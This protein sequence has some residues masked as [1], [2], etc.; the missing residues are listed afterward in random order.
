MGTIGFW[1]VLIA[2][3]L[4]AVGLDLWLNRNKTETP[5]LKQALI[6]TAGYMGLAVLFGGVVWL[7]GGSSAT[8]AYYTGYLVEYALSFDNLFV[9]GLVIAA[10]GITGKEQRKLLYAGILG[11]VVLRGVFIVVG[12]A[13]VNLFAGLLALFGLFLLYTGYKIIKENSDGDDDDMPNFAKRV[14]GWG[15]PAFMGALLAI[16]GTDLIFALDSIPAI[17]GITTDS[18]VAMSASMMAVLGLRSLYFAVQE[19][20]NK[21]ERLPVYIG[22]VLVVIGLKAVAAHAHDLLVSLG[23]WLGWLGPVGNWLVSVGEAT[24]VLHI[25]AWAGLLVTIGLLGAGIGHSVIDSKREKKAAPTTGNEA[26]D[27]TEA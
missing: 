24:P 13:L 23:D 1:T 12:L 6:Q 17:F 14:L 18:F 25:P 10:F 19:L 20:K 16:E 7:H 4:A 21:F 26:T 15:I 22:A 27:K 5:D 9:I 2:V 11:A 8:S 3:I